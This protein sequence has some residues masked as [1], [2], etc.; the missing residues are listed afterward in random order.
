[1]E[2]YKS[3]YYLIIQLKRFKQNQKTLVKNETFIDYKEVLNLEDFV[4]GPDKNKSLYDLY[5]VVNHRKFMNKVHHTAFC[6]NLGL[7]FLF[8][9]KEYKIIDNIVSKEA[10][11]L[12][13]KRRNI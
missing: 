8:D 7:W 1:M 5:G 13:Y 6:K 2:I 9:D 10:Y 4:L 3:P 11:I 12:F